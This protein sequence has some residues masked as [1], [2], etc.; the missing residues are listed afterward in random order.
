MEGSPRHEH[1][2]RERFPSRANLVLLGW[3][4]TSASSGSS[5]WSRLLWERAVLRP[6]ADSFRT[7]RSAREPSHRAHPVGD[8]SSKSHKMRGRGRSTSQ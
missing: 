1:A 7:G 6:L 5:H 2:L 4:A 8:Y 3:P